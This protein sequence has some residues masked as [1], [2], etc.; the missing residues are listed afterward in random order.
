MSISSAI[1]IEGIDYLAPL[2]VPALLNERASV[3]S[4]TNHEAH[5]FGSVTWLWMQSKS[6]WGMQLHRLATLLLPA[7]KSGQYILGTERGKPVFYLSWASLD[8]EAESRY[9]D[10]AARNIQVADWTSGDRVW[11]NDWIA[12][13]GHTFTAERAICRVLWRKGLA[14]SLYHRADLRGM[15]VMGFRGKDISP[16]AAKE[17]FARYPLAPNI[18]QLNHTVFKNSHE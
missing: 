3:A 6:H 15:R 8:L 12:P 7:I 4:Q 1:T 2:L 18:H 16:Q 9:L 10:G 11:F 13:F 5:I 14:R 17:R